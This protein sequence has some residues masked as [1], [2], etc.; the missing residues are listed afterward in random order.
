M[1]RRCSS[2]TAS[3][4]S[5]ASTPTPSTSTSGS[6]LWFSARLLKGKPPPKRP[7]ARTRDKH[8][9]DLL[10]LLFPNSINI[11]PFSLCSSIQIDPLDPRYATPSPNE[12]AI[13][14][15]S[16]A[17]LKALSAWELNPSDDEGSTKPEP[18]SPSLTT[19]KVAAGNLAAADP[20]SELLNSLSTK[21]EE[22]ASS[23]S[24]PVASSSMKENLPPTTPVGSSE[25]DPTLKDLLDG[26]S[27]STRNTSQSQLGAAPLRQTV[28]S[29]SASSPLNSPDTTVSLPQVSEVKAPTGEEPATVGTVPTPHLDDPESLLDDL[30][31]EASKVTKAVPPSATSSSKSWKVVDDTSAALHAAV[32]LVREKIP[33]E[34]WSKVIQEVMKKVAAKIA[35]SGPSLPSPLANGTKTAHQEKGTQFWS[36][37]YLQAV[38]ELLWNVGRPLSMGEVVEFLELQ[39]PEE[40]RPMLTT[41]YLMDD[42]R[43][44]PQQF[45]LWDVRSGL[46]VNSSGQ[47]R[48][49]FKG[50]DIFVFP[51]DRFFVLQRIYPCIPLSLPISCQALACSLRWNGENLGVRPKPE[52]FQLHLR[53]SSTASDLEATG[54]VSSLPIPELEPTGFLMFQYLQHLQKFGSTGI[55]G[56]S[57]SPLSSSCSAEK[58][59]FRCFYRHELDNSSAPTKV[60]ISFYVQRA[61]WGMPPSTMESYFA[62][63]RHSGSSTWSYPR[64]LNYSRNHLDRPRTFHRTLHHHHHHHQD[65][66]STASSTP[67][68]SLPTPPASTTPQPVAQSQQTP[69]PTNRRS[70][71]E[72]KVA[73]KGK[74]KGKLSAAALRAQRRKQI[75]AGHYGKTLNTVEKSATSNPMFKPNVTAE[76]QSRTKKVDNLL[77]GF[78]FE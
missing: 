47:G 25:L 46:T 72:V 10:K 19:S 73:G 30:L 17:V 35:K 22:E 4:F 9:A 70:Q 75:R 57:S 8:E 26:I 12:T 34:S 6:L 33:A 1:R 40:I 67:E 58:S 51:C 29:P 64:V 23:P 42:I 11:K 39:A 24:T 7:N 2:N 28:A 77:A 43:N 14:K 50:A 74:Q 66:H 59:Y 76:T 15:A 56:K 62:L 37:G 53:S 18:S 78:A 3:V 65:R 41:K 52:S 49:T 38:T 54:T 63:L 55:A 5:P 44:Y 60:K 36:K 68:P 16:D 21:G 13:R 32:P 48:D 20:L 27:A 71:S 61:N 69:T 31:S 45:F